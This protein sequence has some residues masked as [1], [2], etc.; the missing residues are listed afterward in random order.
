MAD[1]HMIE[2][3]S[4]FTVLR[5]QTLSTTVSQSALYLVDGR[6]KT[7]AGIRAYLLKLP[8]DIFKNVTFRS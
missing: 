3:V 4:S 8:K 1:G 2:F 5:G 6:T 7:A